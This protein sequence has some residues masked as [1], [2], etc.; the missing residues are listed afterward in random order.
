VDNLTIVHSN[1]LVEAAYS[2]DVNEMRLIILAA[3]KVD[4]R[5]PD[6]GVIELFPSEFQSAF[7]IISNNVYRAMRRAIKGI[8][9]KPIVM[10]LLGTTKTREFSW[11]LFNEYDNQDNGTS[12]RL[13]FN[14]ELSPYL[15]ELKENFTILQFENA[16]KLNTPFSFRLYQWLIKAQNLDRSKKGL[17]IQVILEVDW[18]KTQAGLAGKYERWDKFSQVVIQPA[19]ENINSKTDISVIWKPIR[20]GR[21]IHAIQF[22]YTLERGELTVPAR[23]RLKR[24]T[25]AIAGSHNEGVWMR[26]NLAILIKYQQDLKS[27]DPSMKL[28]I[29]DLKRIVLY[30]KNIDQRIYSE[31][32]KELKD[33]QYKKEQ[34]SKNTLT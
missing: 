26:E 21:K 18:I 11:L 19:I 4:S 2:L 7:G 29:E 9:R 10:P 27:Y 28:S 34:A 15:F 14:P 5:K 33:R 32:K 12:I 25:K 6:I 13:K 1:E 3:S 23:P 22:N 30:S 8:N 24:R 20:R 17:T 31:A 16:A